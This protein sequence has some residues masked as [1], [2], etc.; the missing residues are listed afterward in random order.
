MSGIAGIIRF[1]GAPVAPDLIAGMTAAMAH[2]G[3]DGIRHWHG[4]AA[5]LGHCMLRTTPESL[6]ETQ[7]L[8]NEDESLVL[9]MDG[10]IDNWEVLRADL[11]AV[12]ARLRDHSDAELVLRAYER[13][14]GDCV[15]HLEGDFA[16]VVWDAARR[17]AFC[18]RDQLGGRPFQ[19][20]WDGR[21][22]AFASELHAVLGLPWVAEDINE[23]IIAEILG[24][25]RLSRDETLWSGVR[26][27][28]GAQRMTV[29]TGRI[30]VEEYWAP[31]LGSEIRY[32]RD[33]EYAEHYRALLEDIVRRQSRAHLPVA[34]EVSGGIDS[35]AVFA[36]GEHLRREGQLMAPGFE[37]A[38]VAFDDGSIADEVAYARIVG[39]HLGRRIREVAPCVAPLEWYRDWAQRYRDFPHYPNTVMTL[40]LLE[41]TAA[42]GMRTVLTGYGGDEWQWG[43]RYYYADFI[44]DLD[45]VGLVRAF[46]LDRRHHGL[47]RTSYWLA[48]YGVLPFLPASLQKQV[49]ALSGRLRG[50][51]PDVAAW[52]TP[53]LAALLEARRRDCRGSTRSV[54]RRRHLDSFETLLSVTRAHNRES[55]DALAASVGVERRD[56]LNSLPMVQFHF[57]TPEYTRLR[58][59]QYR[60]THRT[61]MRGLLPDSVLDRSRKALFS[62]C[63][64]HHLPRFTES[65]AFALAGTRTDWVDGAELAR[66][67]A[68][69]RQRHDLQWPLWPVWNFFG[70]LLVSES[71]NLHAVSTDMS[72]NLSA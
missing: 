17:A 72:R 53:R 70:C 46:A 11:V 7:P 55:F 45:P 30:R 69:G 26:R 21:C 19:Y 29:E 48:R 2:R 1:D 14:G 31:D 25:C 71:R 66:R 27:L 52:L 61:A 56:P 58:A 57:S 50:R 16:F 33:A 12:G 13:W 5:A 40:G 35:S 60:Y 43:R 68:F 39:G 41:D 15:G 32:R 47:R 37:G 8:A 63:I 54:S 24:Y 65:G 59:N 38:T 18:A 6:E 28:P 34:C 44:E 49:K 4:G 10:R 64:R 22:L 42:R 51:P 3:P 20:Y 36:V 62:D 67:L 9:V 23:G